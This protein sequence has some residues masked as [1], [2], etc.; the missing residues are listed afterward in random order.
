MNQRELGTVVSPR[1]P[2][3]EQP[4]QPGMQVVGKRS[5]KRI[6]SQGLP[7]GLGPGALPS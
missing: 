3:Q 1:E 7:L 2:E 6:S 4:E 5:L